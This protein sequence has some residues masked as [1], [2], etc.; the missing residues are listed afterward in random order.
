MHTNSNGFTLVELAIVIIITGLLMIPAFQM[1]DTYLYEKR[2]RETRDH[3][4]RIQTE[5]AVFQIKKGRYPCPSDRSL[6]IL[7]VDFGVEKCTDLTAL[8]IGTCGGEND[9]TGMCH[10]IGSR[11]AVPPTG[12][13]PVLMGGIPFVTLKDMAGQPRHFA[14][15]TA[16]DGWKNQIT[17]AVTQSL[18]ADA[19]VDPNAFSNLNGVIRIIDEN[20]V[21][22][23]G[24][25]QNAHY[26][27]V[28]HGADGRGGFNQSG[29]Q[30]SLC[31]SGIFGVPGGLP[32]RAPDIPDGTAM[33]D[34]ENC[35]LN[36]TFVQALDNADAENDFH[37]DDQIAFGLST[38]TGLWD[39]LIDPA[40][41]NTTNNITNLNNGFVGISQ[42]G[43]EPRETLDVKGGIRAETRIRADVIC[44]DDAN[45]FDTNVLTGHPTS[46]F[47]APASPAGEGENVTPG[48]KCAA[49]RAMTGISKGDEECDSVSL[50]ETFLPQTCPVVSG[51]QTWLRGI[52]TDGRI[53]C[54]N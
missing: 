25:Q 30:N 37:Y 26:V 50:P 52:T 4:A 8:A 53:I 39:Y 40:T 41:G 34:T 46:A 16:L 27:L 1:Y 15:L 45:C 18:S 48:I 22:T 44:D 49:G 20:S 21:D 32:S 42:D 6:S 51:R 38:T 9:P 28:S 31:A 35:N 23:G 12:N 14:S 10:V 29:R 24:T 17:Y 19:A 54:S 7:S 11:D 47:T 33:R 13:D 43:A 36:G 3:L 5:L 2:V